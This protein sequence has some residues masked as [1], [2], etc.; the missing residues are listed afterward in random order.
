MHLFHSSSEDHAS[1]DNSKS[2]SNGSLIDYLLTNHFVSVLVKHHFD[3]LAQRDLGIMKLPRKGKLSFYSE[4]NKTFI[5]KDI[6]SMAKKNI[7][8]AEDG[9]LL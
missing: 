1:F 8:D 2:I 5:K 3:T 9:N 7:Y 4:A 6:C